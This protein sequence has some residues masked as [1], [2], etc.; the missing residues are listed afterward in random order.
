MLEPQMLEA[1]S[2]KKIV[3]A[4]KKKTLT[5]NLEACDICHKKKKR[6]CDEEIRNKGKKKDEKKYVK[7]KLAK[8][9]KTSITNSPLKQPQ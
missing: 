5:K 3:D 8:K 4:N 2:R 6:V 1:L 7:K 9:K